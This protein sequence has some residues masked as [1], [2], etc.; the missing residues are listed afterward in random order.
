LAHYQSDL[1]LVGKGSLTLLT[2]D[3]ED[4][5]GFNTHPIPKE[6]TE[7]KEKLVTCLFP[8]GLQV[9]QNSLIISSIP[10]TWGEVT[11]NLTRRPENALIEANIIETAKVFGMIRQKLGSP[12]TVTSGYRPPAINKSV[13]GVSNS[14][15]QY[16]LALDVT[17]KNLKDLLLVIRQILKSR[18]SGGI[19]LGMD[20]G[21]IHFDIGKSRKSVIEFNY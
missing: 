2:A 3:L 10:L 21:F 13:G 19:G 8:S 16:G 9:N 18:G 15:H 11:K 6:K 14:Q 17:S 7:I 20:K 5:G 4:V 12:I 1:D